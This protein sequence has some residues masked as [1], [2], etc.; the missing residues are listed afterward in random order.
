MQNPFPQDSE[1][2]A[3]G[4]A[5]TTTDEEGETNSSTSDDKVYRVNLSILPMSMFEIFVFT[6]IGFLAYAVR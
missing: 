1:L 2:P 3:D 4:C 5:T 6:S